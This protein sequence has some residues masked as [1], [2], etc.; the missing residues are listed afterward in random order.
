LCILSK[1]QYNLSRETSFSIDFDDII[2]GL[3]WY[4]LIK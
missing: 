2:G 4:L 1:S 3:I